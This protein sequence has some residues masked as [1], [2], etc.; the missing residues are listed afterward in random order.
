MAGAVRGMG[1]GAAPSQD[2]WSRA[3]AEHIVVDGLGFLLAGVQAILPP[4]VT[5]SC[6]G[7]LIHSHVALMLGAPR[8][9][10]PIGRVLGCCLLGQRPLGL[11]EII[12]LL[13]IK[14]FVL[15]SLLAPQQFGIGSGSRA[16]T[17]FKGAYVT[18]I[19]SARQV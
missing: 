17:I 5:I 15:H 19:S 4:P 7:T 3:V 12:I 16:D 13:P 10:C 1:F 11:P 6:L 9:L 8:R 18:S 2:S 14:L